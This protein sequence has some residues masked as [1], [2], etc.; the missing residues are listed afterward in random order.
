MFACVC[1]FAHAQTDT[2]RYV[3][4]NGAYGNDGKSWANAKNR[5]QDAI[6]DLKEYMETY[7]LT[8][9]SVYIAAG[10]YVPTESTES[11]G[12]SM[13]STS[14]KIYAGIHV[15]GG[16]DPVHPEEKPGDRMMINGKKVSENWSDPSGIGTTS[17][18]SIAS[19]WDLQNVTVLTGNHSTSTV[20]FTFDS[21]RGRFNTT[22]PASSYHVVWFATNGKYDVGENESLK[23]HYRPL[24][25]PASIDGCVISSGNA[26]S[27]S[28]TSREHTA[29]GGGVYMV[30]NCSMRACIVERCNAT[31]RGGGIY[32]DGGG[33]I[34]FCKIMQ[35]QSVGVGVVQGYGG[36]VCI[37]HEGSI[38]H[39]HIMSCAARCGG[40]LMISHVSDEYPWTERLADPVLTPD[41]MTSNYSPYTT[42]CV[43]NNNTA[44]AE[45]G[46]IYLAEG[47][48]VNH[49]TVCGNNCSGRDVTYYGRRHGRTGGIY[50]R[51]CGQIFNSVFWGNRCDANNDIQFASVRQKTGT[52]A[53]GFEIFAYHTAFMNHDISDWTGVTKEEVYSLDL[54][55]MPVK[56]SSANYPCFFN[57]TVDPTDWSHIDRD[58]GLYGAGVFTGMYPYYF[59]GPRLWHLTSY[60]A[61]DQKG[62]QWN[63]TVQGASPWLIHAH[64]DYGV[65][66]NPYEPV[67]TLGALVRKPDALTY[68]LVVPQSVEYKESQEPIPTLFVDPNRKGSYDESGHFVAR[69]HEG[70]SWDVPIKDLGEALSFFRKYMKQDEHGTH[71]FLIPARDPVTHHAT[72]DSTRYDFVQILVKEGTLTTVGPGNY[73][74]RNI[75]TAAVRMESHMRM[76]GGYPS[77][78]SG[79]DTEGRN[80]REYKSFITANITGERGDAGY[81]NNSA[82]VIAMVN[83]EH[84]IV[85]GFTLQDANTY[86]IDLGTSYEA[87]GGLLLSNASIAKEKRIHMVYNQIRNCV[88]TNCS[89]PKGAAIYV[90]G[91]DTLRR[92]GKDTI[93]YAEL[94]VINCVIRN[95]TTDYAA[96]NGIIAAH[97]RA[98]IHVEHCTVANN[99]GYAFK[100]DRDASNLFPGY[101]RVDNSIIFCNADQAIPDNTQL[102]EIGKVLCVYPET[103]QYVFGKFNMFD[104]DL[105]M[106]QTDIHKPSG[107]FA[108]DY[109]VPATDNFLPEGIPPFEWGGVSIRSYFP[110]DTMSTRIFPDSLKRA[111]QCIL[112]RTDITAPT[113]PTFVNPSRN[114]GHSTSGDKPL[115]GGMVAYMPLTTNPCVNAAFDDAYT[116]FFDRDRSDVTKRNHGGAPDVGAI[117]N[118]DL[119]EAGAVIYVTPEGAGKRDGSSWDNAIAGN[120][121]YRLYDA[122]AAEGDSVDAASGARLISKSG[123]PVLTTENRYCGGYARKYEYT[124]S[125][126]I[127]RNTT[128]TIERNIYQ[129]GDNDH[130]D[131][132]STGTPTSKIVTGNWYTDGI[133]WTGYDPSIALNADYPYGEM[134]GVSRSLFRANDNFSPVDDNNSNITTYDGTNAQTV[135]ASGQ[136]IIR[137]ERKENYVSGLQY[138]VEIASIRNKAMHQDSVQVWVGA[139][140]YTDYKGYVMRDSVSVYGGFPTGKFSAPGMNERRA[141]MSNVVAIPKSKENASLDAED[142]ETILQISDTNPKADNTTLNTDAVK[143]NDNG[144][145]IKWQFTKT[146][147][148]TLT[149]YTDHYYRWEYTGT[150]DVSSTYMRYPDMLYSAPS[151][152]VFSTNK[153]IRHKMDYTYPSGPTGGTANSG[154]TWGSGEKYV[155][156]YFGDQADENR[157]WELAYTNI[158]G[159]IDW[160]QFGFDAARQVIGASGED[161]ETVPRGMYLLGFMSKMCVWQTMRN[162][163]NGSYQLQID[164]GAYYVDDPDEE[165]TGI[166]F[167]VIAPNGDTL[168]EQLVYCKDNKLRRYTFEFDQPSTGDM[169]IR[170]MSSP[171][172]LNATSTNAA[173]NRKVCMANV[174]LNSFDPSA[175]TYVEDHI[176]EKD[177]S[178]GKNTK[179]T[180]THDDTWR[181]VDRTTLRKR[182]LQMPDVTNPVFGHGMGDP[183]TRGVKNDALAHHERVIK[184]SRKSNNQY[185]KINDP[186]YKEYNEVYW[187]GFTIRHGFIY[188]QCMAHGGGAGVAMYEGGHLVNC[189]VTDNWSGAFCMKGG[190]VFCDGSTSTIENCFILNNT[191]TRGTNTSTSAQEQQFAGGLFLYEGTCFNTLIANNYANGFGGGLGLC[192]GK[193]YNNTVAYNTGMHSNSK[194]GNKKVGGLRIASGAASSILISNSILYG[195]NGLA[196]DMTDNS[197]Y[198]PFLHC[199]IQSA[200]AITKPVITH[201]INAHTANND[202]NYGV[203]NAFYNGQAASAATTPFAADV[204]SSGTFIDSAKVRN[205]FALR[206]VDG[207]HCI[208]SGTEDFAASLE[209]ALAVATTKAIPENKRAGY[210]E[211]VAGVQLPPNDVVYANRIQDCQVDIG[212]YEYNA[213]YNIKPDTTTHPGTAIFYTTYSPPGGDASAR[214]PENAAC[215][216]KLQLVLDAAGRYKYNLMKRT[217]T[218]PLPTTPISGQPDST[219]SVEIWM[220][221]DSI[222]S[223]TTNTYANWYTPTRSTRHSE[224]TYQ[225]N[226]LDYSFIV[227]HGVKLKGGFKEDFYH[228]EDDKIVDDRD[229]LTFRTVLSGNITSSTGAKGQTYHVVTF[230]NDLFSPDNEKY[231]RDGTNKPIRNQLD[232]ILTHERDRAVLDGLFIMDGKANGPDEETRI[233]GACVVTD[234]AHV[235]NCVIQGNSADDKGGGLYLKPQA[236]VSGTIVKNNT[237]NTGGG[238]YIEAPATSAHMNDSLAYIFNTTVCE[239]TGRASAGGIFF[240]DSY[241]RINSSAIWHNSANDNANVAGNFARSADT[242]PYPLNCCA[243][244]SRRLEGQGNI[245][246]SPRETEGV[247]WDRQ[248]PFDAILYYPIE[249]S[250]TLARAGISYTEWDNFYTKFATLDSLDIAGVSRKRW[251]SDG[252]ERGFAWT[253]DTLVTKNNDVIDIG[254]RA[255]NKNYEVHVDSR[256]VM[257]RLFVV[258]T[259]LIDSKAARALQDNTETDSISNMYR[260]MGS[261]IYN[262]FH[263]LDDAFEY[264]IK[265]RKMDSVR[266]RN[267]RFEVFIEQG[268]YYPIRDAYLRQGAVRMNTFLVPEAILIVGGVDSRPADHKYGQDGFTSPFSTVHRIGNGADVPIP[269]TGYTIKYELTDSIRLRDARHRPM[270]DNNLNSVIEPWELERQTILSGNAVAGEDFTHVY[271]VVT[272]HADNRYIGPRPFKFGSIN[273]YYGYPG[274]ESESILTEALPDTAPSRWKE[275]IDLSIL[276]R[277]IGFDGVQITGGYANH[278]DSADAAD[279]FVTKTYFRGGGIY[280]D[281]NW[282]E[283]AGTEPPDMTEP[284][285]HDIPIVVENCYFTNNMAGNGGA[286]YS[287][288]GIYAYGNR[289]TQNYS[290]GPMTKFDQNY[291][292]WTAGGCIATNAFCGVSNCLFDNNEARRGL[293]PLKATSAEPIPNADARQGFGGCLSIADKSLTRVMNCHFMKNKAVAYSAMYN[294]Y[295]NNW[296]STADSMQYAFNT[297]F[298]G[299]EVFDVEHLTDLDKGTEDWDGEDTEILAAS[300]ATFDTNYKA[301]RSGVFHYD[302]TEWDTYERLFSEY[303]A[304][305]KAH[306]NSDSVF[307]PDVIAKLMELRAQGNK[308]EG[309]YFCSYRKTYGP[310]GMKPTSDGYLLTGKEYREWQDPRSRTVITKEDAN[311]DKVEDYTDM[312][313]QVSGNNNTLIN[314]INTATDGPNFKQPTFDA[315]I[316]GYMQNA[317]WL[318]ARMNL[319]TDQGWGFLKQNVVRGV[320]YYITVWTGK[321]QFETIEA[322][323]DSALKV[324]PA[325]T[326]DSIYAIRGLPVASFLPKAEQTDTAMYNFLAWRYGRMM[327][328]SNAPLPV[329][330]QYYMH[331]TRSTSDN[332]MSGNM[333]RISKNPKM[334]ITD[335]YI[336][337]G[338]YEYQYVQLDIHGQE[339]DTV[340]VATKAKDPV[341]QDGLT[342]E[343]PTTDMQ[344]A[345][346][347]LM[348]SHNNHDKY[349]CLM[350]DDEG[351]TISPLNVLDNRRA[352]VI[353]SNSS[354]TSVLLPDSAETDHDYGVNSLTFLGGYSYDVKGA[355]RDPLAHPTV[356]EM[357]NAGNESQRN[358]LFVVED[359]TRQMLQANFIGEYTSRDSVVIPIVFDG[360]TFINPYSTKEP[361]PDAYSSLGGQMSKKGGAAIYYRWQRR[362]EGTDASS[363]TPNFHMALHPDSALID[364]NKV[365]LPKMT[366]SNCIF[367]DNGKRTDL[368]AERSPAVRIDHGGGSTLIVNTLF[369]S[370]AGAPVYARTYDYDPEDNDLWRVPNDVVMINVTSALND[371]HIRLESENSEVHNS[372]IWLDDLASD[373]TIQLQM[374]ADQWD[375]TTNKDREG[376]ADRM[377]HNAVWGC[378]QVP[379]W[380]VENSTGDPTGKNHPLST[381]NNDVYKG[382]GFFSP[383]V[384]A[385]TS[386][387]RRERSFRLNPSIRTVGMADT[388]IYRNKVFFHQYPDDG[389]PHT[390]WRRSNGFKD[391]TIHSI[392]EDYDLA[393]N[394]RWSNGSMERGAY[395]CLVTLQRVLYVNP[396]KNTSGVSGIDGSS[397]DKA[398][399]MGQ[400]QNAIDA[401]AV[402]TYMNQGLPREDRKAYVYVKGTGNTNYH[403]DL[404]ARDGVYVY[405]S[406][407]GYFNNDTAHI[408]TV[409]GIR[410]FTNEECRRFKNY[411]RASRTGIATSNTQ[412]KIRSILIAGDAFTTGFLLDGFV[413][414]DPDRTRENVKAS[415]VVIDNDNAVVRNC[416]IVDNHVTNAEHPIAKVQKGLLY[417]CLFYND[418]AKTIVKVGADGLVLNNTIVANS[419]DVT[420][421]DVTGATD[422]AVQNNIAGQATDLNCFAPYMTANNPYT[423]PSY[424]TN[425]APLAF[426]LH[427]HSTNI[428]SGTMDSD[429]PSLFDDYK[430]DSIILFKWDRDVLGNP[431]KI[432]ESVDKGA[433]ETW[434]VAPN[435]AQQL[436]ALTNRVPYTSTAP[437]ERDTAYTKNYGGHLYPH[438]GSVVYLMDSAAMTM[439]YATAGDFKDLR[440]Q[441][442]V[443]SPGFLLLRPGASF[444]G[445][446]HKAQI[447]YVAAEKK[448]VDQQYAMTSFP[449][450]YNTA[451]ITVTDYDD[452]AGTVT[453]ELLPSDFKFS[454][455]QYNGEARS[456]KDYVFQTA[457]STLW[458]RIDTT[459]RTATDG[460][461]MKFDASMD[462]VLRFNAFAPE[463][464]Q[465][466]YTE[467]GSNKTIS[468]KRY[469][470][471]TPGSGASLDFTR[472]E[473]MGWNMKGLPWL[474][475]DYRT[476]TVLDGYTYLRQM[477]IPH[478][479]Y[480]M[481]G[482]GEYIDHGQ[483]YSARSW[484]RPTF[485]SMGNAFLTQTATTQESE[486]VTF[487]QPYFSLND[488]KPARP[489]LLMRAAG[490]QSDQ[491]DLLTVIADTA[492]SKSVQYTYGR[493]ALKW[494]A[495]D[496]TAQVY[497]MDDKRLSHLSILG[498]APTDVDIPLGVSVPM[499]EETSVLTFELPEKDAF[500]DYKYVWLIDYQR[501]RYINLLKNDYEIELG[502]GEYHHRFA[503]RIGTFPKTDEDGNRKYIVYTA[504]GNLYVR[505]IVPGDQIAV[506]SPTGSLVHSTI[507]NANEF[508][509]PLYHQSGFIVRVNETAH[510]VVNW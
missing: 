169:T 60:S 15:Y 218:L 475:S 145:S 274:H 69:D 217:Y 318:Q 152:N 118:T 71:Y 280:V 333:D 92:N 422:G 242:I 337:L 369:H 159:N 356:I 262:P 264:I 481:D 201:A 347:L 137:N 498:A 72:G 42:A 508:I 424:L 76:Y 214:S 5:V 230:T 107:F 450:N 292:P 61:L 235:R 309:L 163:P 156:Q 290:Q 495:N 86:N 436:S 223:T 462:T 254:A 344:Y 377:T 283:K 491:A 124:M 457:N 442:V 51:N 410:K 395:E 200:D 176:T 155:Y 308:I 258:H 196:V 276:A 312:W 6:N 121:V 9:G 108:N 2:I 25:H 226:T 341:K 288:G 166:T 213:A 401:A 285:L 8:S 272:C 250:S 50:V 397:W 52:D 28:T 259:D 452:A 134:S 473:D 24:A 94:M 431:R 178:T 339:I 278:L 100:A 322:A 340:W 456:E 478:V 375:K 391:M 413:I 77:S 279:V 471:R 480:M 247:R 192:V 305:Y 275:E 507:A 63:P 353:S 393:S 12:G 128:T 81:A 296:Y 503:I 39:S 232:T 426:Q 193:F 477:H 147:Y 122:P 281:G 440:D 212:A 238:I 354:A 399:G 53:E 29:F 99:V 510:K 324:N 139:G 460:Y 315:G 204:N 237:A 261:C 266:Y 18:D 351:G 451:N 74:N 225:D 408:D 257:H 183:K 307:H 437:L 438:S 387:Q 30:G 75:R 158:S 239:N 198:A 243:V 148:D 271:H 367:M 103:E 41:T 47:G 62:V 246:L 37:D 17:A 140:K 488:K 301:S 427:E 177:V 260:Q 85:D 70:D 273:P 114:I 55:N 381:N 502:G 195:N 245:E 313:T 505:G 445:N 461:L 1:A 164:L 487:Y 224:D 267:T 467:D 215:M 343:T 497:L 421:L 112:T 117:E 38:G 109:H 127:T 111:N 501:N 179:I 332:E 46:G 43:I 133:F 130:I 386:E 459:N 48:T 132:I 361:D 263:R 418:S 286:I 87:G 464:N 220:E 325:A 160:N 348:S 197:D 13:L 499:R 154:L 352:F 149:H 221:G 300:S 157:S 234:Y 7:H 420:P 68:A 40:G 45:G 349:V 444:Y 326:T 357:P 350:G 412:T 425:S 482:L 321:A 392:S 49:A 311:G 466:V 486:T 306:A 228:Y 468:L 205:D 26:S 289:F 255:I 182:V 44:N 479:L 390:Y 143:F 78:L 443:F 219:W 119:P 363:Q 240:Y 167:Y 102:G 236:L 373:T 16:F 294:F 409:G 229:P 365:T 233:G 79:T 88:I 490:Q 231:F 172:T 331:Y 506:Y 484:D 472:A 110:L 32:C 101:L 20:T 59:P 56:G 91:S 320:S 249:M 439:Q 144:P 142:Y 123:K 493:D 485:M 269:G 396:T 389:G 470:H 423:L 334:G 268:T 241:A 207:I 434:Y 469:D 168:A 400:L 371:G 23:D 256:Y 284:A 199:Y 455:Y 329:G 428:N 248:D 189:I 407:P 34:E 181:N 93:C 483:V 319:T 416:V 252:S 135:A 162:V 115:Y 364:G 187:D 465:Y 496:S 244:E 54:R 22:F 120:T 430:A 211:A 186:N 429:L 136:L 382:P 3:H 435:K 458:T 500:A 304:L 388:T 11:S 146:I 208:N 419:A 338:I 175:G 106:H 303:D 355:E 19:Q 58:N 463:V 90:S 358:Q 57:P 131:T 378:F 105:Q 346:E 129:G 376:I 80:P 4:P 446:G 95:N 67:S 84:A 380:G 227:P 335:V 405:G 21:I 206:Q 270:R 188:E 173:N 282:T 64:T 398:F 323:L 151:T 171:G 65:V 314:R 83:A 138:A 411:V 317:D 104:A 35:C 116:E 403:Y 216:Q 253:T 265:A 453:A 366:I 209:E 383:F 36:G 372:L 184:D 202:G 414:T 293:Y 113:F 454:T 210:R 287:N 97:G 359:M 194:S 125:K 66:S 251:Y 170:L 153:S 342:W 141:L 433:F 509:L 82:H 432:G 417:N 328:E 291:I 504:D 448:L 89:S 203:N 474:V 27:R 31:L 476:D 327:S 385:T 394:S 302:G 185:G 298:W 379:A 150:A 180:A 174:H 165:N 370:N 295:P 362:Y 449:Y 345:I 222:G 297:I 10:T 360:I 494:G 492:A 277:T 299:N 489:L 336:D 402:Y 73:L 98:Y 190:G 330:D 96:R 310:T 126:D 368:I 415:P 406:L 404:V 316:D 33:V 447:S 384:T 441:D 191:S 374:G 14:F 161:I